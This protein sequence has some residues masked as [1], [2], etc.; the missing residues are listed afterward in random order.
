MEFFDRVWRY[1]NPNPRAAPSD[2]VLLSTYRFWTALLRGGKN[3]SRHLTSY[4]SRQLRSTLLRFK[5]DGHGLQIEKP[6]VEVQSREQ[7]LCR[8]CG[9]G[10]IEDIK[11]SVWECTAYQGIR[12]K[13]AQFFKISSLSALFNLKEVYILATIL[14]EMQKQKKE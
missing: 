9:Q 1:L 14:L 6:R 2:Q 5:L 12:Q 7:R 8:W 4:L 3:Q 11:H 10:M 13:Y